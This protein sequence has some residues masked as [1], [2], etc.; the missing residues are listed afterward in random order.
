MNALIKDAENKA[1]RTFLQGIGIDI[2]IAVA[3]L[4]AQIVAA[5]LTAWQGW[6]AIGIALA[7]TILGAAAA[8]VMRRFLDP[9]SL[10]TPLPPADPGFPVA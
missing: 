6:L 1:W 5:P 9:S 10:P 7:R 4:V 3:L 8:Y 2:G